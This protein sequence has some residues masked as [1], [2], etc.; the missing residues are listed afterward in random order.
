MQDNDN[1]V[2]DAAHRALKSVVE[3]VKGS[4]GDH[5]RSVIGCWVSGMGDPYGPAASTAIVAFFAA[6]PQR[7]KQVEAYQY[8]FK[9]IFSVCLCCVCVFVRT[10]LTV[11]GLGL[12]SNPA[13]SHEGAW[14]TLFTRA[15]DKP[16][17]HTFP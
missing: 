1:R 9:A 15:L 3:V 14:Y 6:F 12:A 10:R 17:F 16:R 4:I 8:C 2:R 11:R 7:Q 13:P 5:L